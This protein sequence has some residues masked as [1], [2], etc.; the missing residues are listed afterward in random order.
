M[1]NTEQEDIA[2]DNGLEHKQVPIMENGEEIFKVDEKLQSLIQMLN[3]H[4]I[5]TYNSCQDNIEDTVWIEYDLGSWVYITTLAYDNKSHDLYNFME[6]VCHVL[7]LSSDDGQPDEN[8]EYWIPGEN[9]IWS[10]S[11][12]FHKELLPDFELLIGKLLGE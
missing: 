10:A 12:R 3:N 8:D 4:E 11:V 6:E 5:Y 2:I 1:N 9:L 7:L